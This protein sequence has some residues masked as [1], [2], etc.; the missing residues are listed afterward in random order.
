MYVCA[1][2]PNKKFVGQVSILFFQILFLI[3]GNNLFDKVESGLQILGLILTF[4]EKKTMLHVIRRSCA[5][6]AFPKILD[7]GV[8]IKKD[9]KCLT[10][11]E[12]F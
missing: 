4:H 7:F 12:T 9:Y 11:S 10:L 2:R 3:S 6:F 8:S 5:I 1:I